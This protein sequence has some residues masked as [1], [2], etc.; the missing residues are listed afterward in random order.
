MDR[1]PSIMNV[2]YDVKGLSRFAGYLDIDD[3]IQGKEV[4]GRQLPLIPRLEENLIRWS[5][6][7]HPCFVQVF[8]YLKQE[9]GYLGI[10][11][12]PG[13]ATRPL[14]KVKVTEISPQNLLVIFLQLA[15]SFR[16]LSEQKVF[17]PSLDCSKILYTKGQPIRIIGHEACVP[18]EWMTNNMQSMDARYLPPELFVSNHRT[19]KTDVY[20]LA[21]LWIHFLT[22]NPP[23]HYKGVATLPGSIRKNRRF[24][25]SLLSDMLCRDAVV[26][27]DWS[28]VFDRLR[29]RLENEAGREPGPIWHTVSDPDTAKQLEEIAI[30]AKGGP[31]AAYL[32]V[33]PG[34]EKIS[35]LAPFTQWAETQNFLVFHTWVS[36]KP[37]KHYT[38]INQIMFMLRQGASRLMKKNDLSAELVPLSE[39]QFEEEMIEKWRELLRRIFATLVPHYGQGIVL[40]IED[41]QN[42]D[43]ASLETLRNFNEMLGDTPFLLLL[44]GNSP[45]HESVRLLEK[46]W[47]YHWHV[48]DKKPFT[49]ERLTAL[50][51]KIPDDLDPD[52]LQECRY[53]EVLTFYRL[54]DHFRTPG[55]FDSYLGEVW[56]VLTSIQARIMD[57]AACSRKPLSVKAFATICAKKPSADLEHLA[58]FGLLDKTCGPEGDQYEIGIP[59]Y[60]RFSLA[61]IEKNDLDMIRRRLLEYESQQTNPDPIQQAYLGCAVHGKEYW[62]NYVHPLTLNILETLN[63]SHLERI[64][65]IYR[66]EDTPA[67]AMPMRFVRAIRGEILPPGAH[68]AF[69]SL[70]VL[71]AINRHRSA[72]DWERLQDYC[73]KLSR[74]HKIQNGLKALANFMAAESSFYTNSNFW[75]TKTW[76]LLRLG[77]YDEICESVRIDWTA[78]LLAVS[79]KHGKTLAEFDKA[80]EELPPRLRAWVDGVSAYDAGEFEEAEAKFAKALPAIASSYDI[81]WLGLAHKLHG[82]ALYRMVKPAAAIHAYKQAEACFA[83]TENQLES[84]HTRYNQAGAEAL[85]GRYAAAIA[86]F[87]RQLQA[88]LEKEDRTE[89]C[90]ILFN[91]L[92]CAICQNHLQSLEEYW[93]R[94]QTLAETLK[95]SALM[96]RGMTLRLHMA[97]ILSKDEVSELMRAVKSLLKKTRTDQIMQEQ[98]DISLRLGRLALGLPDQAPE[99]DYPRTTAWRHKFI[100]FLHGNESHTLRALV[101]GIGFGSFA[102]CHLFLLHTAIRA[103]MLPRKDFGE[104]LVNAFERYASNSGS[105]YGPFIEKHFRNL[106]NLNDLPREVWE[107]PLRILETISWRHPH[108]ENLEKE[109]L[110]GIHNIWTFDSFGYLY[111][112]DNEWT[113]PFGTIDSMTKNHL[114]ALALLDLTE[115]CVTTATDFITQQTRCFL[116]LPIRGEKDHGVRVWFSNSRSASHDLEMHYSQVFRLYSRL[117]DYLL[118]RKESVWHEKSPRETSSA[119]SYGI[120]GKSKAI[121]TLLGS[122]QKVAPSDLNIFIFGES[123]TGKELAARAFH[124]ASLRSDR[125]FRAVNCSHYPDTLVESELFGHVKGAYTGAG[126]DKAGILELVDGG[127][128]FLDEIADINPKVQSLLLRVFQ[129]GEFSRL[130]E[131]EVRKVDIRFITATNR[132]L[133][134]LIREGVFREDLYFR[135]VEEEINMPPLRTRTEDLMV[136]ANHFAKKHEPER[137]ITFAKN[138]IDLMV[139][140]YWPGNVREFESYIRKILV[141]WPMANRIT[142]AERL[143]FLVTESNGERPNPE[144]TLEE[145]DFRVRSTLVRERLQRFSGNRT[146][147]AMSLGVSRQTLNNL[148]NKYDLFDFDEPEDGD[149]MGE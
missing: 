141:H 147:T 106:R 34:R 37:A 125:P 31:R 99:G 80:Y 117:F 30:L 145:F 89:E 102:G 68:K 100:D 24:W 67:L 143:P 78:R 53:N 101:K 130:G 131:T 19:Q 84:D 119:K 7:S 21:A 118:S 17:H 54:E 9:E 111:R 120:V 65:E 4:L 123:G 13:A 57:V 46:S 35:R 45:A 63:V 86:S 82:N 56:R 43:K 62:D 55:I 103:K 94:Y 92:N 115:P 122:I 64:E 10:M 36:K 69:P 140:H 97:L 149:G 18:L 66:S 73:Q 127:T 32:Q 29:M 26:R 128:L 148:M 126:M 95:N 105:N 98:A 48:L 134:L 83:R 41:V 2:R 47:P 129:E 107:Q 28:D 88:A 75:L 38:V 146:Q 108:I 25:T 11:R 51:G 15:H 16:F 112:Q 1:I 132:D 79:V 42:M 81:N 27:L 49:S 39:W 109:L 133:R 138:F 135:M 110:Q 87:R 121:K 136:L 60:R 61:R 113:A 85:A 91:L 59:A 33:F 96:L 22:G 72:G 144:L 50:L 14:D 40:I 114:D 104:F 142:A 52:L 77:H 124:L 20:Y 74:K 116:I 23:K 139:P 8:R 93:T 137:Q 76:R 70:G 6:I 58:S 3:R 90:E 71:S 44:T 5:R 12:H